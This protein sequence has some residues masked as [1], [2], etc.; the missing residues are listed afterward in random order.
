MLKERCRDSSKSSPALPGLT[1]G[2]WEDGAA[3]GGQARLQAVAAE[4]VARAAGHLSGGTA[5][6]SCR[7][8][9]APV[10]GLRWRKEAAQPA[11]SSSSSP[12]RRGRCKGREL[13]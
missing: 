1:R 9:A 13:A 4:K 3:A 8:A 12:H 10:P 6:G 11:A 7:A 2:V 5:V